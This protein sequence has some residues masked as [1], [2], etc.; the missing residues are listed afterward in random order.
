[1]Q[2]SQ[3]MLNRLYNNVER[4][5]TSSSNRYYN[6]SLQT[7]YLQLKGQKNKSKQQAIVNSSLIKDRYSKSCTSISH[8]NMSTFY[9]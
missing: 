6:Q 2:F 8:F 7:I 5:C 1:M 9:L 4:N 3:I